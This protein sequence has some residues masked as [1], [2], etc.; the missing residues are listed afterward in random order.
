MYVL[1]YHSHSI[2]YEDVTTSRKIYTVY[3]EQKEQI[4]GMKH[5]MKSEQRKEIESAAG[6]S[7][8]YI[9]LC[10]IL[11]RNRITFIFPEV[12]L[13]IVKFLY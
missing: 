8:I 4:R 3:F 10:I 11:L 9:S 2:N 6:E 1:K 7:E 13:F 5:I 12:S